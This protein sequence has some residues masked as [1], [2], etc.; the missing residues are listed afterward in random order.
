MILKEILIKLAVNAVL[1]YG[2]AFLTTGRV[3]FSGIG[4]IVAAAIFVAPIN[5]FMRDLV[6]LAGFPDTYVYV[7]V[8]S[9]VL[10]GVVLYALSCIIPRFT[11]EGIG[12]AVAYSLIMGMGSV[13]LNFFLA[14]EIA[15][16]F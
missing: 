14:A 5:A 15:R 4:P 1:L 8:G 9:V 6:G 16:L 12:V 11:V 3:K 13:V 7:F 10:N 2:L